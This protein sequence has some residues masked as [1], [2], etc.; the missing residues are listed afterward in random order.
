MKRLLC[1]GAMFAILLANSASAAI[2]VT[3]QQLP[4]P[5]PGL[6]A[7]NV[8]LT[9][10]GASST[11]IGS[12]VGLN[13]T[14][15]H[16]VWQNAA[17][18]GDTPRQDDAAVGVFGKAAWGPLDTYVKTAALTNVNLSPGFGLSESN[19]GTNP[20]AVNVAPNA[21]FDTFVGSA[22]IGTLTATGSQPTIAF[23]APQPTVIDLL[24]VVVQTGQFGHLTM[25]LVDQSAGGFQNVDMNIGAA[26]V[27]EPATFALLGL[28]LVGGLGMFRR[29][30]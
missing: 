6:Q 10:D 27:P 21:P 4:D 13:L 9:P 2:I 14:N 11:A 17:G 16:Q 20:T 18:N 23:L 22:G 28:S 12:V 19:N 1:L 15:V 8:R 26:P 29:R 24:Q 5:G 30:S 3:Q 7:F 25:Q